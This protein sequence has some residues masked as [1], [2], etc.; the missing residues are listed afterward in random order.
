MALT[1]AGSAAIRCSLVTFSFAATLAIF[2]AA[3]F[4]AFL[5]R[6][7][8]I[9]G[10]AARLAAG[11][12]ALVLGTACRGILRIGGVVLATAFGVF[13]RRVVMAATL[14]VRIGGRIRRRRRGRRS[15]R[16][17]DQRERQ[18][19]QQYK[20]FRFHKSSLSK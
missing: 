2:A 5:H 17:T 6:S 7:F 16:P 15:L 18:R 14:R 12:L 20:Q 19:E 1:F 11:R 10:L 4:R 8:H 3:I 9:L 13:H